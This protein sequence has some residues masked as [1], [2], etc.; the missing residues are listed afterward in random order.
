MKFGK[1]EKMVVGS[2]IGLLVIGALDQLVFRDAA[3]RYQK[4]EKERTD[5]ATKASSAASVPADFEKEKYNAETSKDEVLLWKLVFGMDL[6]TSQP[7]VSK[8]TKPVDPSLPPTGDAA[9]LAL[10]A[11]VSTTGDSATGSADLAAKKEDYRKE[12]QEWD[13]IKKWKDTAIEGILARQI[14]RLLEMKA[15]YEDQSGRVWPRDAAILADGTTATINTPM[16]NLLQMPFLTGTV[17]PNVINPNLKFPDWQIPVALQPGVDVLTLIREVNSQFSLLS[18]ASETDVR[19]YSSRLLEYNKAMVQLESLMTHHMRQP[20]QMQP[21]GVRPRTATEFGSA[22]PMLAKI[23][24]S[25]LIQQQFESATQPVPIDAQTPLNAASLRNL[26]KMDFPDDPLKLYYLHRQLFHLEKLLALARKDQLVSIDAVKL[27]REFNMVSYKD[28]ASAV[29]QAQA[30]SSVPTGAAGAPGAPGAAGAPGMPG[31]APVGGVIG[32]PLGGGMLLGVTGPVPSDK[33]YLD[34]YAEPEV[35]PSTTGAA[36]TGTG[37]TG[38][39]MPGMA[40]QGA[41]SSSSNPYARPGMSPSGAGA[42]MPGYGSSYGGTGTEAV[43]AY[44]TARTEV[45]VATLLSITFTASNANAMQYLYDITCL[46]DH[47][48]IEGMDIQS[49]PSNPDLVQVKVMVEAPATIK[50]VSKPT[51]VFMVNGEPNPVMGEAST[52]SKALAERL[53]WK[54]EKLQID[55]DLWMKTALKKAG[56]PMKEPAASVKSK[57]ST[58]DTAGGGASAS[59]AGGAPTTP[60]A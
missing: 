31:G 16:N 14:E 55:V 60:N 54:K 40:M 50:G 23:R 29:Q 48:R 53:A 42:R 39:T 33:F 56:L 35:L 27:E 26:F 20:N 7:F 59:T 52:G 6:I 5:L 44:M 30:N 8:M 19:N 25:S 51:D 2:I 9:T 12:M 15:A 38:M 32:Q 28:A 18:I 45:G 37:A 41:R 4:L 57:A 11:P 10:A 21:T 34:P 1:R 58:G 3:D 43:P 13:K 36:G 24:L 49:L 17:A 22:V 47:F 46:S